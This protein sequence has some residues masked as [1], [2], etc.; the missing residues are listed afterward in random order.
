MCVVCLCLCVCVC[1]C[2]SLGIKK[3]SLEITHLSFFLRISGY[4]IDL[5]VFLSL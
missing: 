5:A 4:L 2:K 3:L 1:G